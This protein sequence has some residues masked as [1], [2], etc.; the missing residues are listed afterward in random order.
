[1]E[2]LQREAFLAMVRREQEAARRRREE[3]EAAQR[4]R[5]EDMQRRHRLLEAAFDGNVGEIRAV[6]KEVEDLLTSEGVGHDEAGQARRLQRCVEM[7]ECEDS[8]HNTPLSEAAA[9]GQPQ[10]IQLLAERGRLWPDPA[11]PSCLR[12]PPGGGGGAAEARSR[13]PDLR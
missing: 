2:K 7:V 3:E 11:V 10:A 6:L 1:M 13:P 9:G 4:R 8:N 5:R 12:G